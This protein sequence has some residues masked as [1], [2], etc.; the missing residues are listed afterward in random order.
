MKKSH[1]CGELRA[2][3]VGKRV[4]LMGWVHRRRV[5]GGLIFVDL[6]DRFGLT[7]LVFSGAYSEE[8]HRVAEDLRGEYVIAAT[9]R[10]DR[11]P[12]G[13]TNPNLAT[14]EIEVH[15]DAVEVL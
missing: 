12:E 3:D 13:T 7:Q 6:R 8:A 10:V 2:G 15:V 14:G 4:N 1:T 5:H 11:R 9:G